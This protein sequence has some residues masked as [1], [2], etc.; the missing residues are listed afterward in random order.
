MTD[1]TIPAPVWEVEGGDAEPS[2]NFVQSLATLLLSLDGDADAEG[3]D[4][5]NPKRLED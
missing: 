2:D 3:P 1:A 5:T 4:E